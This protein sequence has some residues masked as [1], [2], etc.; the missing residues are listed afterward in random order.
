MI[1]DIIHI[2]AISELQALYCDHTFT[3]ENISDVEKRIAARETEWHTGM[4]ENEMQEIEAIR[5]MRQRA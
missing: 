1:A 4:K 3:R 2:A 5:S